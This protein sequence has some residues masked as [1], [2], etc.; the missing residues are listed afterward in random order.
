MLNE[1]LAHSSAMCCLCSSL[2]SVR[3]KL[4]LLLYF[5]KHQTMKNSTSNSIKICT[6][7]TQDFTRICAEHKGSSAAL[8]LWQG[9]SRTPQSP[10]CPHSCARVPCA[11]PIPHPQIRRPGSKKNGNNH[12]RNA[13]RVLSEPNPVS[14]TVVVYFS[15]GWSGVFPNECFSYTFV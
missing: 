15:T 1:R 10:C 12:V 11:L 9:L 13:N 5:Q 3:R 4:L 7:F 14:S 2:P 6:C 8:A